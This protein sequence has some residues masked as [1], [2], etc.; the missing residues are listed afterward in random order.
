MFSCADFLAEFG[1]YLDQS[2]E[3]ALRQQ[4]EEHL[5]ECKSCQV[6]LDTTRKTIQIVTDSNCFLVPADT[7]ESIISS[8]MRG[9]RRQPN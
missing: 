2:A 9:V 8:V 5:R 3:P 1:E 7:A 6:M 4:L